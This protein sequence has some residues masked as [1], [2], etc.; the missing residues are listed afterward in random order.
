MKT[1]VHYLVHKRGANRKELARKELAHSLR[2]SDSNFA[3]SRDIYEDRGTRQGKLFH[4]S[5]ISGIRH[6]PTTRQGTRRPEFQQAPAAGWSNYLPRHQ[7]DF[8]VAL[9][10]PN[11][12]VARLD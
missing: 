4:V 12:D 8:S 3:Q 11:E 9:I 6:G 2:R 1:T 7:S 5:P 10:V